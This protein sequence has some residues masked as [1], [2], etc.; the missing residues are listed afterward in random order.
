MA[1]AEK[2]VSTLRREEKPDRENIQIT[3]ADMYFPAPRLGYIWT[4]PQRDDRKL[5][6]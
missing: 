5:R 2:S 6:F 4:G 1:K 3:M